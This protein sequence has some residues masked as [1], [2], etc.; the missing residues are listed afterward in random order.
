MPH[1]PSR[2]RNAAF[3]K[4]DENAA[5]F[6]RRTARR[7][8]DIEACIDALA[9]RKEDAIASYDRAIESEKAEPELRYGPKNRLSE[10]LAGADC[11]DSQ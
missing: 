9:R 5:K 7:K 11:D 8:A 6:P 1:G 10:Q 2:Q 4:V 3:D